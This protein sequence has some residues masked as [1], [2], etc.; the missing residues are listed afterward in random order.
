[1]REFKDLNPAVILSSPARR[2][3]ETAGMA[4]Q[5]LKAPRKVCPSLAPGQRLPGLIRALR[6]LDPQTPILLAGH[7]PQLSS[8][9]SYLTALK[10]TKPLKKAGVACCEGTLG[11]GKMRLI[12]LLRPKDI[13]AGKSI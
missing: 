1:L 4:A 2:A 3:W 13:L 11:P 10:K 5:V 9:L 12:W 6:V 8:L 7:E